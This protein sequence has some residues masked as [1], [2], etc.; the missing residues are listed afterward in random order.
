MSDTADMGVNPFDVSLRP[1]GMRVGLNPNPVEVHVV[2][3]D[4]G[5]VLGVESCGVRICCALPDQARKHLIDLLL[6]AGKP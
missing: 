3:G 6:A 2:A 5:A 4:E 1:R